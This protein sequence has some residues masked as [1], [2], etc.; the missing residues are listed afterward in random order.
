MYFPFQNL[1][2]YVGYKGEMGPSYSSQML[3]LKTQTRNDRIL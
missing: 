2:L 1:E 3:A